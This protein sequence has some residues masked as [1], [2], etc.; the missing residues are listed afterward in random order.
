MKEINIDRFRCKECGLIYKDKNAAKKCEDW[1]MKHKSCNLEITK[2]AINKN[3][4]QK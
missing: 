4:L 3:K 1:C 2:C